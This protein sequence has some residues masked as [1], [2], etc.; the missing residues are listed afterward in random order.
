MPRNLNIIIITM[1]LYPLILL[2]ISPI[3]FFSCKENNK[4]ETIKKVHAQ[5]FIDPK[6]FGLVNFNLKSLINA[7]SARDFL[8]LKIGKNKEFKIL[9]E[10]QITFENFDKI[11]VSLS[12]NEMYI[13]T[14]NEA[15]NLDE[16]YEQF[17]INKSAKFSG[18]RLLFE[19]KNI[20]RISRKEESR[21][22]TQV[23]PR[24]ILIGQ[25]NELLATL[26]KRETAIRPLA[27]QIDF[28]HALSLLII[29][30]ELLPPQLKD[31]KKL[32]GKAT[33]KESLEIDLTGDFNNIEACNSTENMLRTLIG[34]S[35]IP[36]EMRQSI[37]FLNT[38][39]QLRL[40]A[41]ITE[42]EIQQLVTDMVNKDK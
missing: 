23:S 20:F 8:A 33:L 10:L 16:Y 6:A 5:D 22:C 38:A 15:I 35:P 39:P 19:N 17:L 31:I 34:F 3:L 24:I 14:L 36:K 13:L 11:T 9:K 2:A 21:F 18:E 1:K 25:Q 27:S 7:P 4:I 30:S 12:A 26:S 28:S 40:S 37:K 32:S 42:S 29:Q 41:Q